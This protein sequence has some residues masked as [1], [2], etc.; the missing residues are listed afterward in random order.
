M[1][2]LQL[3]DRLQLDDNDALHEE[4]EPIGAIEALA[5]EY[6]RHRRLSLHLQ[7]TT[8]KQRGEAG[9]VCGLEQAGTHFPVDRD[10][11]ADDRFSDDIDR[12]HSSASYRVVFAAID[13]FVK[14]CRAMDDQ[15]MV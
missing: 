5:L 2:R 7:A 12:F 1:Y 11:V 10:R 9:F 3:R 15:D 14:G 13:Q 6:Y 8:R 4:V